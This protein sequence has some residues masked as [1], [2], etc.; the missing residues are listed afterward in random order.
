MFPAA[1]YYVIAFFVLAAISA[2]Y[3][4]ESGFGDQAPEPADKPTSRDAYRIEIDLDYHKA[5]FT[6]R[7]TLRFT[8]AAR[9]ELSSLNFYLYPN[10]GL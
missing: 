5:S 8:N 2:A 7:E 9:E 10:F 3:A 1:Q 4:Q 6:G